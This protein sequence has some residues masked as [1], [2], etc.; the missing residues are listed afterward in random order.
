MVLSSG[1]LL[2]TL[3]MLHTSVHSLCPDVAC[4]SG[5]SEPMGCHIQDDHE[6]VV[7]LKTQASKPAHAEALV[8]C[9]SR[10]TCQGCSAVQQAVVEL[11]QQL[12]PLP[13]GLSARGSTH[14]DSVPSTQDHSGDTNDDRSASY[15]A[16]VPH[17][18]CLAVQSDR[19][20]VLVS[21]IVCGW[22]H[23]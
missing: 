21:V 14:A 19:I 20:T 9:N 16:H 15:P 13:R 23:M 2:A 12:G 11:K 7:E 3:H 22:Q 6:V 4:I 10:Q 5:A 8:P 1:P 17:M 18:P